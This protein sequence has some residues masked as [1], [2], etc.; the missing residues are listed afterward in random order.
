MR[1]ILA[2]LA[3]MARPVEG[4][5]MLARV[6]E[7]VC[8]DPP[9]ARMLGEIFDI[10]GE[11]GRLELREGRGFEP[12]REYVEG[13]LLGWRAALAGDDG[14]DGAHDPDARLAAQR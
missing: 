12:E 1:A 5:E 7:S 13:S 14:A 8:F 4:P 11:Y 6:A 10:I 3:Q 2:E 9:M